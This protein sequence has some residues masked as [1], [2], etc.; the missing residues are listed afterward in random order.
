MLQQALLGLGFCILACGIGAIPLVWNRYFYFAD[1]FQTFF[2][3]GFLEIARQLKSGLFPISAEHSWYGGALLAEYQFAVFNPVCLLLYVLISF[4]PRLE[5]A[6]AFYAIA[7]IGI[8]TGGIYAL[9]R[10]LRIGRLEA[11]TGAIVGSTTMWVVYWGA[12]TWI[13][14]LVGTAWL[15][16]ALAFLIYAY[17][18][19]RFVLPAALVTAL[20]FAS[21]WPYTIVALGVAVVLGTAT[22]LF[23][24][25]RTRPAI[26]VLLSTALA[27]GLAAPALLP[28]WNYLAEST[29]LRA[30]LPGELQA[31]LDTLLAVGVPIF[32]DMWRTFGGAQQLTWSP[33]MQYASWFIPVVLVNA[34]WRRLAR[35][36]HPAGWILLFLVLAF[37]T[38]STFAA[39]WHFRMPFRLLPDYHIALAVLSAWL[40]SNARATKAGAEVWLPG[41]TAAAVTLPFLLASLHQPARSG[42]ELGFMLVIGTL[43]VACR[44]SQRIL[45]SYL[46]VFLLL[47]H[48]GI[49]AALTA[50]I[51]ENGMVAHWIP[52][53]VAPASAP[54]DEGSIRQITLFQPIGRDGSF[55][56]HR[57]LGPSFWAEIAPGNTI[58][59]QQVEAINGYSAVQ[60]R[61]FQETLCLDYMGASCPDA[62]RH[63]FA[64]EPATRVPLIDLLRLDRVV[65]QKGPLAASFAQEAGSEWERTRSGEYADVF[66]R[67]VPLP[68]APRALSFV[69]SGMDIVPVL[70]RPDR[71]TF[72][73]KP[74]HA[75]ARL[76]FAR[77]WYPGL[78]AS[79]DGRDLPVNPLL[80]L[81]PSVELPAGEGGKLIVEYVPAGLNLGL[82]VAGMSLLLLLAYARAERR[83]VPTL[84]SAGGS[85]LQDD[86]VPAR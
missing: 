78:R 74:G 23:L 40:L 38:M 16:W 81:L 2:M 47:G 35:D 39:G 10:G 49:F 72:R 18:D 36:R 52:P 73:L 17:R 62:P 65:V 5:Q 61:G 42:M 68:Q 13:C 44:W 56:L 82:V 33:P 11:G 6:A 83:F 14:A 51:P 79:L 50:M 60:P 63:L 76:V 67:R 64:R 77:P 57:S 66:T 58:L 85:A 70:D 25:R 30:G 28:L 24:R 86:E 34:D 46:P 7:H 84:G 9:C 43:V 29:R 12:Q 41:R 37:G 21:G 19:G 69:P 27:A 26:R 1:D 53:L 4:L 54:V 3:P 22:D 59:Y 45:P 71:Q 75:G 20:A 31:D 15:C 32:P 80:T 8:L 55:G 48:V